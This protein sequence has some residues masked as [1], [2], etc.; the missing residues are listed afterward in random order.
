MRAISKFSKVTSVLCTVITEI[1]SRNFG[2]NPIVVITI[3]TGFNYL[4]LIGLQ[5]LTTYLNFE[6]GVAS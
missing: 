5:F 2:A 6:M 4:N 1:I 3:N